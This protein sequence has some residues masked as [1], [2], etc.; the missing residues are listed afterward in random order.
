MRLN[1]KS[2]WILFINI[3]FQNFII[4]TWLLAKQNTVL[5]VTIVFNTQQYKSLQ[6]YYLP[7]LTITQDYLSRKECKWLLS[8]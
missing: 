7:N 5:V 8:Q 1:P 4:I 2:L 3:I 6:Y